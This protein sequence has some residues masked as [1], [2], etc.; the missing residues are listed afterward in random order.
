MEWCGVCAST[1][2]AAVALQGQIQRAKPSWS[3]RTCGFGVFFVSPVFQEGIFLLLFLYICILL[4]A[5]PKCSAELAPRG[6]LAPQRWLVVVVAGLPAMSCL[7]EMMGASVDLEPWGCS[8][9]TGRVCGYLH[10]QPGAWLLAPCSKR[11]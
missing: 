6:L 7:Q 1:L 4:C 2:L 9:L 8:M 11:R 5:R 10:V 3:S